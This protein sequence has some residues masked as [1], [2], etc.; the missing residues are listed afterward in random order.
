MTPVIAERLVLGREDRPPVVLG[1][2]ADLEAV[3]EWRV[4]D[5]VEPSP[6]HQEEVPDGH[7]ARLGEQRALADLGVLGERRELDAYERVLA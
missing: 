6:A 3:G 7:E 2:R 5:V 4:R 1:D